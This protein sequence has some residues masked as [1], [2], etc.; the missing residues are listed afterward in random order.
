[1]Q[2]ACW[3]SVECSGM[4][5]NSVGTVAEAV[6]TMRALPLRPAPD[7]APCPAV[8]PAHMASNHVSMET[9]PYSA[10]TEVLTAAVALM[11][12]GSTLLCPI[13]SWQ[14]VGHI[15]PTP[16]LFILYYEFDLV[17]CPVLCLSFLSALFL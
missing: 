16:D 17:Y 9:S 13:R 12:L 8:R 6:V 15:L 5:R 1:M 2:N 4:E 14:S 10:L 7:A 11:P 3:L